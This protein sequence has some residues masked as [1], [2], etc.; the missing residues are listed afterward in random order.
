MSTSYSYKGD[1]IQWLNGTGVAVVVN[2]P[3]VV[4]NIGAGIAREGIADAAYG[5]V[6]M[7]GVHTLPK[8]TSETWVQ[9][10]RLYYSTA[11][12]NCSKTPAATRFFIG[13]A[14]LAAG[15]AA[16]TGSVRL[17]PFAEHGP[18]TLAIT[19]TTTLAAH[20]FAGG[21]VLIETTTTGGAITLNLPALA[22]VPGAL[23]T[24]YNV[25]G[26]NAVTIDPAA[27]E[28]ING[29]ATFAT[30]D[31]ANDRATFAAGTAWRLVTSTI[32]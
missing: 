8:A 5:T 22:T 15:S 17:A 31:A 7:V 23:L 14:D 16:T 6:E 28:Q 32:A 30:I 25:A 12:A 3:V 26:T 2:Q 18:L 20:H 10:D 4:G 24:V 21:A 29:G 1:T 11:S 9:G 13:Y 27:S 19:A